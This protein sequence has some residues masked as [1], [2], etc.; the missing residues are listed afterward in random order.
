[1]KTKSSPE[2]TIT[3][4]GTG[5]GDNEGG[6]DLQLETVDL[7]NGIAYQNQYMDNLANGT[8]NVTYFL[9]K[10]NGKY[11][12]GAVFEAT[13]PAGKWSICRPLVRAVLAT[14]KAVPTE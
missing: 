11:Q 4:W 13:S 14:I 3:K 12:G 7:G 9:N 6:G 5:I 1:M 2:C 8:H 10:V